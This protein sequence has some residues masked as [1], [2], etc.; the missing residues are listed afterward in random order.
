MTPTGLSATPDSLTV[1]AGRIA[2]IKTTITPDTAPQTVTATTAGTV[3]L[4]LNVAMLDPAGNASNQQTGA[5]T[6]ASTET[7]AA[8]IFTTAATGPVNATV[9]PR[10]Y[11]ID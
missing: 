1:T 11:K 8:R 9:T 3:S 5:F 4:F 10:L 2:K 7:W 6:V